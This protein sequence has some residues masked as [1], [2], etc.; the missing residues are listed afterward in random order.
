MIHDGRYTPNDDIVRHMVSLAARHPGLASL[1]TV[2]AS[3]LGQNITGVRISRGLNSGPRELLKPMVRRL[4]LF[5]ELSTNLREFHSAPRRPLLAL[6]VESAYK[7]S[8]LK[9]QLQLRIY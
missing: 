3:S 9:A 2:G 6:L 5:V 7:L 1:V 8:L 4:H